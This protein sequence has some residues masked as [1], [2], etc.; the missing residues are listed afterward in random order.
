MHTL[1]NIDYIKHTIDGRD[2]DPTTIQVP[3]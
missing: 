1:A 3:P 2:V